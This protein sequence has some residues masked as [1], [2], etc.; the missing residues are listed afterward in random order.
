MV[1]RQT[2]TQG[3]QCAPYPKSLHRFIL[4]M[5]WAGSREVAPSLACVCDGGTT[6]S[7]N[8]ADQLQSHAEGGIHGKS[9]G[10]GVLCVG[11]EGRENES[12]RSSQACRC[13]S[14]SSW[15]VARWEFLYK[16]EAPHV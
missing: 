5:A 14:F 7:G 15:Q 10:T 16:T 3:G 13:G 9:N 6:R 12:G 1:P 2:A 4:R 11:V 8:R